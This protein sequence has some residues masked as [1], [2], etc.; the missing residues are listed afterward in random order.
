MWIVGGQ[1]GLRGDRC[2]KRDAIRITTVFMCWGHR[3][4]DCKWVFLTSHPVMLVVRGTVIGGRLGPSRKITTY[5]SSWRPICN[6]MMLLMV[7][8]TWQTTIW[9]TGL[10]SGNLGVLTAITVTLHTTRLKV[11]GAHNSLD[12]VSPNIYS[13]PDFSLNHLH[14]SVP[15]PLHSTLDPLSRSPLTSHPDFYPPT[16]APRRQSPRPH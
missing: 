2:A 14:P 6:V 15:S 4:I 13:F 3:G 10:Q 7:A 12:S 1:P 5:A 16:P 9:T 11:L 8:W